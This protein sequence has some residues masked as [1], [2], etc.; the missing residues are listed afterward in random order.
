[1]YYYYYIM[2]R[3][4]V[5]RKETYCAAISRKKFSLLY[6]MFIIYNFILTL[7]ACTPMYIILVYL[8]YIVLQPRVLQ[9]I[10]VLLS[11]NACAYLY[12]FDR[13]KACNDYYCHRVVVN[14]LSRFS[15]IPTYKC[16]IMYTH[17][18]RNITKSLLLS[19]Y[20]LAR[21]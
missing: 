9:F 6:F 20:I 8:L 18:I 16:N 12:T 19:I 17:I 4:V 3:I 1:M 5:Y 13:K 15:Y 10:Y 11:Y 21:R 14:Y 7:N 2:P